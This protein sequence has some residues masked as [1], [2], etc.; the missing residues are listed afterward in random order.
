MSIYLHGFLVDDQG[1]PLLTASSFDDQGNLL[2]KAKP[3]RVRASWFDCIPVDTH[4]K[5]FFIDKTATQAASGVFVYG[6][7]AD[8][9]DDPSRSEVYLVDGYLH[10]F[11]GPAV[12]YVD[13]ALWYLDG[14]FQRQNA[15]NK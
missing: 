2:P 6:A 14:W 3:K 13:V 11:D 4:R 9:M 15:V 7:T 8:P 1:Q 10:R 12:V 5:R